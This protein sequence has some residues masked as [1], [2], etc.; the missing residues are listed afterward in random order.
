[1]YHILRTL[2]VLLAFLF[3]SSWALAEPNAITGRVTNSDGVPIPNVSISLVG[4][5]A[6]TTTNSDGR[7]YLI[8]SSNTDS[9]L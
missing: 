4:S 6:G 5:S 2:L 1:M 8:S 7:F 9:I 3:Q